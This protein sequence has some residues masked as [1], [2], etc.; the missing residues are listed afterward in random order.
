[1]LANDEFEAGFSEWFVLPASENEP[2]V[3][4]NATRYSVGFVRMQQ[5][6]GAWLD[7]QTLDVSRWLQDLV[8]EAVE[9]RFGTLDMYRADL[10]PAQSARLR[11]L[12]TECVPKN[13]RGTRGAYRASARPDSEMTLAF[14]FSEN[15]LRTHLFAM[16]ARTERTVMRYARAVLIH[17]HTGDLKV[18]PCSSTRS[19][20]LPNFHSRNLRKR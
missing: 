4:W 20:P 9:G 3:E 12:A 7:A 14:V 5:A 13:V 15:W 17:Q 11:L 19:L 2:S 10:D 16:E 6:R 18:S 1:M 8:R